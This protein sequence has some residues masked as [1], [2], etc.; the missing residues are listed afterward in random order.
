MY[1]VNDVAKKLRISD[2]T[3]YRRIN[4]NKIKLEKHIIQTSPRKVITEEGF[5][6]LSQLGEEK[7]DYQTEL[8][9]ELKKNL[10]VTQQQLLNMQV[11]LKNEQEKTKQL[12]L[13]AAN[14]KP[15]EGFWGKLNY[16]FFKRS[17]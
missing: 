1:T 3:V 15:K 16:L 5:K 7:R 17:S 13:E 6:I 2:K 9:E 8:I 11:L 10:E 12:L 14:T 4:A